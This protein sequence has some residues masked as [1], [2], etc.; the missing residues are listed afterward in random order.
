MIALALLAQTLR[1]AVP[2]LLAAAGGVISERAG[3]VAL[4]LEAFLLG[5]A[6]GAAATG[7][8][9]GSPALAVLGGMAAGAVLALVLALACLRFRADQ[10]VAGIALNLVTLGLTRYLLQLLE[11]RFSGWQPE[12]M[13]PPAVRPAKIA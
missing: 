5:G 10:V 9:T 4:G 1:I 7:L 6:F 2:Y 3:V 12:F 8:A 13:G 11:Q